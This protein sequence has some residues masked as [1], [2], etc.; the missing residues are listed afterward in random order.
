MNSDKKISTKNNSFLNNINNKTNGNQKTTVFS[1]TSAN[2]NSKNNIN[3]MPL[4]A[5]KEFIKP[6]MIYIWFKRFK[7]IFRVKSNY[8]DGN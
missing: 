8:N 2:N 1:T 4:N 6:K 3:Y 7:I 5:P